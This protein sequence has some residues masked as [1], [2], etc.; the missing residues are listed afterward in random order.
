[1][2]DIDDSIPGR[3]A[4]LTGMG[5]A[6]VAGLAASARPA[7]AQSNTAAR[8]PHPKDAWLAELSGMHKVFIDSSTMAGG[9]TALW[10]AGNI[11]DTHVSEYDGQTSDYALVVCFRH[12]STPYG[13]NDAMW[14]KYGNLFMR[15]ADPVPTSN[16]MMVPLPT[17]GQH[18]IA[19][20]V[21]KGA[22][23][24]VCGRATRR[25][26]GGIA[27]ATGQTPEAVFAELS[28]NLIP[29][30]HLVP[31]GVIAVTRAQEYGFAFLYAE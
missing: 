17:N 12:L 22:H 19:S 13:F 21:E 20:V 7:A 16:P 5:I 2:N 1:M 31:A 8:T 23:F 11:L 24:A 4:L 27:T 15:N 14:A 6:A 25:Q 29:R 28:A 3:R 10:G 9:G 26:A 18:S 30:A